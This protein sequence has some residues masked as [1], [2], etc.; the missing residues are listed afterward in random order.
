MLAQKCMNHDAGLYG[1]MKERQK[2]R[3]SWWKRR[4]TATTAT[5]TA[6]MKF[7]SPQRHVWLEKGMVLSGLEFRV[8]LSCCPRSSVLGQMAKPD[9]T[10]LVQEEAQT[11]EGNQLCRK[12][13]TAWT[14]D[15]RK[16]AG[17]RK[18][19]SHI[20]QPSLQMRRAQDG[21]LCA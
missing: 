16:Y 11:E 1:D 12:M 3:I 10:A 17:Q 9:K 5:V 6:R 21:R 7:Q 4:N 15:V 2:C 8:C 19:P 20:T 18:P 14:P 13:R